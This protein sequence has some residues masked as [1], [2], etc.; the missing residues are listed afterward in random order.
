MGDR[1]AEMPVDLPVLYF[2]IETQARV[3]QV[4]ELFCAEK[5]FDGAFTRGLYYKGTN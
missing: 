3:Q 2:T 5:P 4:L 1:I